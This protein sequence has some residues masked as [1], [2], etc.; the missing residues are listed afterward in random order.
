MPRSIGSK[1]PI[2]V[3]SYEVALTDA[4]RF[5]K[6]YNWK[7]VVVDEVT[8]Q[9][10]HVYFCSCVCLILDSRM[11]YYQVGILIVYLLLKGHRL[12]NPKC[13][14]VK[15]LKYLSIENKLLLTGTPL[16]NNLAELW[17]LLHFILPDIFSSLE[18]FESWSVLFCPSVCYLSCF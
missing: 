18:E 12:K 11:S 9:R 10:V 1:F 7:Y 3:T 13:R 4:R 14:L 8:A 2:I 6:H 17:S 5:L 16:Q 15:E